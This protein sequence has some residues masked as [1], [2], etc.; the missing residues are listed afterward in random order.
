[1]VTGVTAGSGRVTALVLARRGARVTLVGRNPHRGSDTVSATQRETGNIPVLVIQADLS[2]RAGVHKRAQEFLSA[3]QRLHVLVNNA[4]GR[5]ALRQKSVDS[6]E[7]TLALNRL[8][9][10]QLI[11]L[12]LDAVKAA[13]PS[14]TVNVA[15]LAHEDVDAFDFADPQ[16]ARWSGMDACPRSEWATA[17]DSLALPWTHPAFLHY[18]RT[19]L[20]N[21]LF[22]NELA[23]RVAGSGVTRVSSPGT[24]AR[25]TASM[26]GSC[27][28]I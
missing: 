27:V 23:R 14:R 4:G 25:I 18:A 24:S 1:M 9:R 8:G 16:A 26:A 15:S 10:F 6:I 20:A 3:R 21:S 28:A 5:F 13:T 12:L 22:T 17:F 11:N 7:M 19:K 2:S